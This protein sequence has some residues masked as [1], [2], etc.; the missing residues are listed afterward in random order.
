MLS[1]K[2][3]QVLLQKYSTA[4]FPGHLHEP[5]AAVN[6]SSATI[7]AIKAYIL[8]HDL[9]PGDAL[10]TEATLC[11]TLQV[12][13]SSVREALRKLEAL[14]IVQ[15]YQG[16]GSFVGDMSL[17]PMVETLV[18]RFALDKSAGTESL[19]QVVS[20]RRFIDLGV[21]QAVTGA[22]V[23][24]SNPELHQLVDRMVAKA[25]VGKRYMDDDIAFH[26]GIMAYLNN[27][28]LTQLNAAMWLV[29]RTVVPK[30]QEGRSEQV[31]QLLET[32]HAHQRMLETAEAGD[33][34]AYRQAVVDHYASLA[35]ILDLD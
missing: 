17:E 28:L 9:K 30:L 14:D 10:P 20:M 21:A 16:R 31:E 1:D 3:A 32:A 7:D 29:H 34:H 6:R 15:V 8:N 22:M 11:E 5:I 18:L 26:T 4:T 2:S 19:R 23:G 12:S 35:A 27:E 33:T 25:S 24:T 13:R